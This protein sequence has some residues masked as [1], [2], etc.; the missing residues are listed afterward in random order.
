MKLPDQINRLLHPKQA[1]E[2]FLSLVLSPDGI[3]AGGWYVDSGGNTHGVGFANEG[4]ASNSWEERTRACDSAVALVE[5]KIDEKTQIQKVVLGLSSDYVTE[6]GDIHP[7]V[8][9]HIKK[10]TQALDLTP[11]GFVSLPQ[12]LVY[13]LK[14]KEGMPPSVV[15]VELS[16]HHV[17]LSLYKVGSLIGQKMIDRNSSLAQALEQVLKEFKELEVLPSRILLYGLNRPL[18]EEGKAELL[19]YP[20]PTKANFLHFP[21]I[22][23]IAPEEIISSVSLAGASEMATAI[24]QEPEVVEPE[25]LGFQK[26]DILEKPPVVEKPPQKPKKRIHMPKITIPPLPH[27]SLRGN[28]IFIVAAGILVLVIM[29]LFLWI[30]PK[31]AVT[32]LAVPQNLN[33]TLTVTVDPTAT[34][35][36][37]QNDSIPGHTREDSVSGEKTIPVSGTKKVGDPAKG[38]VTIYNKSL[39]TKTFKK[40]AILTVSSLNFTLDADVLVASASESIGSITFG[41]ATGTITAGSIGAE[42]NLAA[43]TEFSFKDVSTSIAL[44]RNDQ[45]LTGGTSREVTVVSRSDYD[46]LVKELTEELLNQSKQKLMQS[47]SGGEKLIDTTL[48]TTVTEKAFAQELDEEAKELNGKITISVSGVSYSDADIATLFSQVSTSQLQSGYVLSPDRIETQVKSVQVKKDGKISMSVTVRGVAL[49]SLDSDGIRRSIVGM[50]LSKAQ[51]YLQK[52]AGVGGVEFRFRYSM[53][54]NRLPINRNNISVTIA[55]QQ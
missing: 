28:G 19:K 17:V 35:A 2:V 46:T 21:K 32:I 55:V 29:S 5:E 3:A 45:A 42:S 53:L 1:Y 38:A 8:R 48:K 14:K 16:N 26:Q 39:T 22:D 10:L 4:V 43:G 7:D 20:W 37:S 50:S 27:V 18:V 13:S 52:T 33:S 25:T 36:D 6:S 49:P 23:V 30:L 41:K 9:P 54:P 44:A 24:A 15:L 11:L 12:A 40:G 31:A 51:E 47:V 34:V